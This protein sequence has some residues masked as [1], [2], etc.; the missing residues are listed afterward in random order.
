MESAPVAEMRVSYRSAA[1]SG[2]PRNRHE[3]RRL[4]TIVVYIT[5]VGG[6]LL[7]ALA[8]RDIHGLAFVVRAA[9]VQGLV[10]SAADFETVEYTERLVRLPVARDSLEARSYAPTRSSRQTVLL[11]PGLH[12]AGIEETRLSDSHASSP[13][14]ASP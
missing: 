3:R 2:T 4:P 5:A 1:V 8:V 7:G 12:V 9:G 6:L 10:R 14:R 11:V 13:K